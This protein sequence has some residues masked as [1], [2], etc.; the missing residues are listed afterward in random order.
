MKTEGYLF[1]K[2]LVGGKGEGYV[3]KIKDVKINGDIFSH[4]ER[5]ARELK[6]GDDIISQFVAGLLEDNLFKERL[7]KVLDLG[8]DVETSIKLAI[9]PLIDRLKSENPQFAYRAQ[10]IEEIFSQLGYLSLLNFEGGK[11]YVFVGETVSVALALKLKKEGFKGCIVKHLKR[12]SHSALILSNA[13]IPTIVGIDPENLK[14]GEY[15]YLDGDLG[16]VSREPISSEGE[17]K[18]RGGYKFRTKRGEEVEILLNL[19]FPDDIYWVKR[20][21]TGVGLFRTEYIFFFDEEIERLKNFSDVEPKVI[22][23]AF[24]VGGDKFGGDRDPLRLLG[25]MLPKFDKLLDIV[26]SSKNFH[27]MIPM[28]SFPEQAKEFYDY[29]VVK[30]GIENLGFM[31]ETPMSVRYLEEIQNYAKFLSVGTNDLWSLYTGKSRGS[32]DI[33]EQ[34]NERFGEVLKE[35]LQKSRVPVSVCGALASDEEGLK[36]L[37]KLGYRSFSVSPSFFVRAVEIVEDF[38]G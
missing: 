37:L 2:S 8:F 4:L 18:Q 33:R 25:D 19:D 29:V 12:D 17:E 21:S 1:G 10:E 34:V 32:S 16:I 35:S 6:S 28:I 30:K 9:K 22:I 31:V 26:K 5:I 36:F 7:R 38:D 3:V 11:N 20:F 13:G 14:E 23:R 27:I 24:D 15:V